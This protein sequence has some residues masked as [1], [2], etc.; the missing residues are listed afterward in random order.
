MR[1]GEAKEGNKFT[2]I[3][4]FVIDQLVRTWKLHKYG[5]EFRIFY[6]TLYKNLDYSELKAL[7]LS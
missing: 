5:W 3:W 7:T 6:S 4:Y 2:Q 1:G